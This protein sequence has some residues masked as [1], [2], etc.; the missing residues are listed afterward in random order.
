MIF[1]CKVYTEHVSSW[2]VC[3]FA[4][5]ANRLNFFFPV[6]VVFCRNGSL[7]VV[8]IHV[9]SAGYVADAGEETID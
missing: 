6:A 4:Q 1:I 9:W 8:F 7:N 3:V 5:Y 2:L